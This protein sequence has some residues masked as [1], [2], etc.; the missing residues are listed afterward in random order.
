MNIA[1]PAPVLFTFAQ[2]AQLTNLKESWL[3]KAVAQ[4]RIAHRRIG[5]H[6]RF[7]QADL[8]ALVAQSAA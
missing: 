8:D 4:R 2:A 5:K 7:S 3:R 6:V 1:D